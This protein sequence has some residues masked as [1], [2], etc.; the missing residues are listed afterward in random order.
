[1]ILNVVRCEVCDNQIAVKVAAQRIDDSVFPTDQLTGWFS[2]VV[3]DIQKM[4]YLH[5]CSA[6]CL[7]KW[8][9]GWG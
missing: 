3:G 9:E 8:L 1:M 4:P 2:V 7:R 6:G 5:F